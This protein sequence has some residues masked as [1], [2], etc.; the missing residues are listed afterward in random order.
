MRKRRKARELVLQALYS[1]EVSGNTTKQLLEEISQKAEEEE[2]YSFSSEL[3]KKTI[4]NV[5]ILDQHVAEAA[6]NWEYERIALVDRLIL[7]LALAE[8]LFFDEIPPKVSINEAIELAKMYSTAQSGRFVNGILDSLFN[9]F[10]SQN[11]IKKRGRGL[12]DS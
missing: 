11:Q 1:L 6:K 5:K 10:R 4:D 12:I 8:L 7:R 2:I 9:K 3:L